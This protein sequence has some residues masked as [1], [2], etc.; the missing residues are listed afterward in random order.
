MTKPTDIST[1]SNVPVTPFEPP[2]GLK[3]PHLQTIL[4][5]QGPRKSGRDRRFKRYL[6]NQRSMILDGG[7][8]IRLQGYHNQSANQKS[9]QL[10]IL[11][12]GWEGSHES[13]YMKSMAA[14]LLDA[15]FDV[16]RLNLRDHGGT[17]HLNQDVFNSTMID[18]V[19]ASI[20]NL[21]T[22]LSYA[23][24]SLVGF[25]LGGNFCLRVAANAH[26]TAINLEQVIAFCPVIHAEQSN[27]VLNQRR[28]FVYS[29]YFVRKWRSS[30][31]KKL[32]HWPEYEF[33]EQLNQFTN[34]NQM[35]EALIPKY[36]QFQELS[37]YFD[38][39]AIDG[40][41]LASTICPCYLHFAKDDMII[42]VEGATLL[43]DNPDLHVTVTEH[44]G[45]CGYLMNWRGDS[46]QDVRA[47]EIINF[48]HKMI[49]S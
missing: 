20:E 26:Q 25:S 41:K 14:T 7:Q 8:D 21:Q 28:N 46:W 23:R 9:H 12:H 17:H 40:N 4:S 45:H 47:L 37:A 3:N 16:F 32:E 2:F 24:Y 44:G 18:E 13:T 31:R 39:Y 49:A 42:P 6:K 38:A 43:A 11:I 29:K 30:L 27:T 10:V 33:G 22:Q 19:M 36:T 35:N 1:K 5:S 15:G 34:L 48:H